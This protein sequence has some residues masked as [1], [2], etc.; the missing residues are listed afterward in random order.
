M[1]NPKLTATT[2]TE[3]GKGA[4]RRTRRSGLIPAVLYGHGS[5][6]VHISLPGKET[7]LIMREANVLLE[8]SV[9]DDKPIMALP[10]Q[11]Q[12]NVIT[13]DIEHVDLVIVKKGEKVT[14]DVELVLTGE[15]ERGALV[16]QDL[17]ALTVEVPAIAIPSEIEVSIEGL[18]IGDQVLVGEIE[19]PEDVTTEVEPD[20]LIVN[21]VPP[22]LEEEDEEEETEEEE[23]EEDEEDSEEA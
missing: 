10:R 16:M 7:F 21:I 1:A 14:V 19:L 15:A 9:G 20:T 17:Q 22:T 23:A 5:D 18:E 3:F 11:I 13:G 12:R 4:A 2:R 8:I 6:T